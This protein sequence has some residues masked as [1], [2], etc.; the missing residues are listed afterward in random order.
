MTRIAPLRRLL[1]AVMFVAALPFQFIYNSSIYSTSSA[2]DY[3]VFIMTEASFHGAFVNSSTGYAAKE[4]YSQF[5]RSRNDGWESMTLPSLVRRY[6][7]GFAN[8]YRD[9]VLVADNYTGRYGHTNEAEQGILYRDV[10]PSLGLVEQ[11]H[12]LCEFFDP[13]YLFDQNWNPRVGNMWCHGAKLSNMSRPF[14]AVDLSAIRGDRKT[15]EPEHDVT[16]KPWALSEKVEM[17][18][19]LLAYPTFW[20][21]AGTCNFA[22]A[23]CL[24]AMALAYKSTPLLTIGDVIDSYLREPSATIGKRACTYSYDGFKNIYKPELHPRE[25][26]PRRMRWWKAVGLMRW[27]FTAVWWIIALF[28]IATGFALG[29]M[30]E[31]DAVDTT[32]QGL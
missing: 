29:M 28:A 2:S 20:W 16:L 25:Y 30:S 1:W 6:G 7:S 4:Q 27:G 21:L 15:P 19:R 10:M 23:G 3:N 5:N 26:S 11:A 24:T 14:W 17:D 13:L 9:V 12:W 31:K 22:I 8:K 32:I 18:C